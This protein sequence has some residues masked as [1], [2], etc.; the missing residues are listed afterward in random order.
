MNYPGKFSSST[1]EVC[2]PL[3]K[4]IHQRES[5]QGTACSRAC[6]MAVVFYSEKEQL[7]IETD[8][9]VLAF[10]ASLVQMRDRMHLPGNEA[11]DNAALWPIVF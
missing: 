8:V 7:Y 10:R 9:P 11:P 6:I 2:E 3:G 4:L 5:G 1:A